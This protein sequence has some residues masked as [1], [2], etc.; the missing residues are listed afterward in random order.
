LTFDGSWKVTAVR[1]LSLTGIIE[2]AYQYLK[3]K[4]NRTAKED[5][6]LANMGLTLLSDAALRTW[7]NQHTASMNRLYAL[8]RVLKPGEFL[9][10]RDTRDP[11]V[12]QL[13]KSLHLTGLEVKTDGNVEFV[14][15]GITDN[16]VGFLYSPANKPP[17]ISSDSHIWVEEIAP[18][19][20]IFRTT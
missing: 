1:R 11:E 19:W 7:F 16:T 17:P 14:I 12:V 2:N 10:D 18:K 5:D 20:F 9:N 3:T 6:D 8:A 13:I 4:P 15:G